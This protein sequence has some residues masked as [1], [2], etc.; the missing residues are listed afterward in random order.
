M[1]YFSMEQI[2]VLSALNMMNI[3]FL[4]IMLEAERQYK[5]IREQRE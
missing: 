5:E 2:Q 1:V 3:S 4:Y